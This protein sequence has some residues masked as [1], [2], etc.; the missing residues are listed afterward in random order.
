MLQRKLNRTFLFSYKYARVCSRPGSL[1][2]NA[3]NLNTKQKKQK[4][5]C[6]GWK[7]KKKILHDF[8]R[9]IFNCSP[10]PRTKY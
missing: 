3:K 6:R 4:H 9:F 5:L 10:A 2:S 7:N 1:K 8:S